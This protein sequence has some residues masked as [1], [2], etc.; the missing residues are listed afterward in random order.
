MELPAPSSSPS[1][2]S[3]P[4]RSNPRPRFE[5]CKSEQV[6]TVKERPAR[7]DSRALY[8][9]TSLTRQKTRSASSKD[10]QGSLFKRHFLTTSGPARSR[11][12]S[13]CP[14]GCS[15]QLQSRIWSQAFR[16]LMLLHKVIT[17][18]RCLLHRAG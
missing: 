9:S 11:S 13:S 12:S 16:L 8:S 17:S 3:S 4:C 10:F 15:N 18:H 2:L 7:W 1:S 14:S 5:V 6:V